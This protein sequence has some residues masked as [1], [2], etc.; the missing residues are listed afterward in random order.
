[1]YCPVI[2]MS[3]PFSLEIKGKHCSKGVFC[4]SN[5]VVHY[6]IAVNHHRMDTSKVLGKF[7][8]MRTFFYHQNPKFVSHI[9][10]KNVTQVSAT[11]CKTRGIVCKHPYN[12]LCSARN[13][14]CY[15]SFV[16]LVPF[17]GERVQGFHYICDGSV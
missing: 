11:E 3:P 12:F 13:L 16:V 6:N 4:V 7:G 1:M 9:V 14:D 2:I 5:N 10:F 8:F 17:L 15:A